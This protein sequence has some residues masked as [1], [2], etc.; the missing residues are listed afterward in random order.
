MIY[1]Y[2]VESVKDSIVF[3]AK[4]SGLKVCFK[5]HDYY[6]AEQQL[7]ISCS[8]LDFEVKLFAIIIATYFKIRN[9]SC[10]QKKKPLNFHH[11][12]P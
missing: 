10:V 7:G 3:L 9:T 2:F 12:G 1:D 8:L 4:P 11:H 5:E 6:D